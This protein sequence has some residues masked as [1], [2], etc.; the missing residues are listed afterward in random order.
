DATDA[1]AAALAVDRA[2]ATCGPKAK[3]CWKDKGGKGWSYK[4]PDAS[5][6]GARTLS[7][8]GGPAAKGKVRVQAGNNAGKGQNALPT[9][10]AAALQGASSATLQVRTSDAQCFEAGLTTIQS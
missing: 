2:A 8:A 3:P 7:V 1:L 5:A 6:S 4:D 10:I 9:G